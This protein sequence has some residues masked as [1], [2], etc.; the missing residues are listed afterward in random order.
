MA[1]QAV[2]N[3]LFV[4][5][6]KNKSGKIVKGM[7]NAPSEAVI[8]ALLRRQGINPT[9][10][11]KQNNRASSRRKQ[12]IRPVDIAIFSRQLATMIGAG[13]PLV[14]ALDIVARGNDNFAMR[15]LILSIR[16]SI[17]GG[18]SLSEALA[19]HPVQF[20]DL[21]VNLVGAGEKSGALETLLDKIAT[22]KEK[23]EAIKAKVR[24]AL[25]Y[26]TVV[27]IVAF[28][29]TGILLYFVVPQ[30]EGLFGSFGAD[31]PAF[32]RLVINLSEF[33]RTWWWAILGSIGAIA[34]VLRYFNRT[35]PK[36]R[37]R[38]DQLLLRVPVIG[39]ILHKAALARFT[40]TLSTMFAAGVPLVEAM[41][42]VAGATGNILFQEAV[43]T[44]REQVAT[45]QQLHLSMQE[46]MDLFP[47]MAI[48]MIA[49]GEESGSLDEMSAKVAEFYEAEVDNLVDNLSTL[50]EPLIMAILG[51]LVGGLV[52]AMY[53]PIFQMGN[54]I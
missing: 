33:V 1:N 21:F 18:S 19:A 32:T 53:L 5:E 51:V 47:N 26:P 6:G 27:T 41:E 23:A 31:L 28:V 52:T 22:Y 8:R 12:K 10:I 4:W 30:F 15:E 46:R 44:M 38:R 7:Q 54:V 34:A 25:T 13:V 2:K 48:Q 40:R 39:R 9:T 50:L 11:K 24:K 17:E 14:Q 35:S 42:S 36:F 49:I 3:A 37:R 20:D 43:M 45:G 29:V 16:A